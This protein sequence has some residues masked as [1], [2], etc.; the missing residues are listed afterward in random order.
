MCPAVRGAYASASVVTQY[1]LGRNYI[2]PGIVFRNLGTAFVVRPAILPN[3]RVRVRITPQLS[4]R[5]DQDKGTVELVEAATE[6]VVAS[7]QPMVIGGSETAGE[8]TR[9][10]LLGY[11]QVHRTGRV[12]IVLTAEVP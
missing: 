10:F 8:G 1:A 5:S 9:Q 12:T 3:Q 7:G 4:Y 6:V 11:E 2:T